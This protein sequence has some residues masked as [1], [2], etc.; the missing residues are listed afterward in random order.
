MSNVFVWWLLFY[1]GNLLEKPQML[2]LITSN[3]TFDP[4]QTSMVCGWNGRI[5]DYFEDIIEFSG[6]G[7][8]KHP[9]KKLV[10]FRPFALYSSFSTISFLFSNFFP[11]FILP[12]FHFEHNQV[13]TKKK[14]NWFKYFPM[15]SFLLT[16]SRI[17]TMELLHSSFIL[18]HII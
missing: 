6:N 9:S 12:L 14:K 5:E 1:T 17:V 16:I 15:K 4:K 11:S 3:V 18:M 10:V 7:I 13:A 2:T 8:T